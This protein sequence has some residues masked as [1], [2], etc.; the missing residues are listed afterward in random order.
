MEKTLRVLNKMVRDGI[1]EQYAIGGAVGA[2]FCIEPL[3]TNDLGVFIHFPAPIMSL[4]FL[5]PI[6]SYLRK[7]G[8]KAE[9]EAVEIEGWPV[10][11]TIRKNQLTGAEVLGQGNRVWTKTR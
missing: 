8:Y 4:D 5:G 10:R 1:I 9:G 11:Q 6:Y 2:I 3:N 7:L